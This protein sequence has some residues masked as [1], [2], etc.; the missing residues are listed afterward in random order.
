VVKLEDVEEEL[1]GGGAEAEAEDRRCP[2][3]GAK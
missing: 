1:V 2:K 3:E